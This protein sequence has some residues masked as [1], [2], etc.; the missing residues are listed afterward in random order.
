MPQ[1]PGSELLAATNARDDDQI[2]YNITE[3]TSGVNG[4]EAAADSETSEDESCG[5]PAT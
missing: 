1:T 2:V 3:P 4:V 5:L